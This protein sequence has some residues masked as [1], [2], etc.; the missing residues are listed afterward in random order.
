LIGYNYWEFK[1]IRAGDT[2]CHE[3]NVA[4]HPTPVSL[5]VHHGKPV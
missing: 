1:H 2:M 4:G 3:P 5:G